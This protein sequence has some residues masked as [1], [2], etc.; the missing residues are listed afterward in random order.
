MIER[1][2]AT[3]K[4]QVQNFGL[5]EWLKDLQEAIQAGYEF[6][7]E[8][9]EGYP[10]QIGHVYTCQMLPVKQKQ[11]EQYVSKVLPEQELRVYPGGSP[12]TPTMTSA[13]DVL[14]IAPWNEAKLDT[15]AKANPDLFIQDLKNIN[16]DAKPSEQPAKR[17]PKPKQQ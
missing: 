16:I 13:A 17:G 14:V 2:Q 11:V 5:V 12:D 4:I 3:D 6:D 7:F 15:E 10:Q 8:T 1:L 9:N